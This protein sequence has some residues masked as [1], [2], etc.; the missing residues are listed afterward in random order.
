MS[1]IDAR[2]ARK[3]FLKNEMRPLK[4]GIYIAEVKKDSPAAKAGLQEG[5]VIVRWGKQATR[6]NDKVHLKIKRWHRTGWRTREVVLEPL[7]PEEQ[8]EWARRRLAKLGERQRRHHGPIHILSVSSLYLEDGRV[9]RISIKNMD[10]VAIAAVKFEIIYL[11][12]FDEQ[13]ARI[14]GISDEG[15]LDPGSTDDILFDIPNNRLIRKAAVRPIQCI[16]SKGKRWLGR[17]PF[18][19]TEVV[20]LK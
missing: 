9:L 11:N 18:K 13:V 1:Y 14:I 4:D 20:R 10:R 6:N 15:V 2:H 8:P 5:D 19:A 12:S 7:S 16:D 3:V 17:P